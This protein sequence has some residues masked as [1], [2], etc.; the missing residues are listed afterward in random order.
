MPFLFTMS[1]K[2]KFDP[3]KPSLNQLQMV[4][5]YISFRFTARAK[6]KY[7]PHLSAGKD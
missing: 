3:I 1:D 5:S 2:R 7:A 4:V 6:Q